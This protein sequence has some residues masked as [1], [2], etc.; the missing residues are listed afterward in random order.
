MP[1]ADLIE[2]PKEESELDAG[3]QVSFTL[4]KEA[5]RNLRILSEGSKKTPR[6]VVAGLVAHVLTADASIK[7]KI[8]EYAD[9]GI[10]GQSVPPPKTG[11]KKTA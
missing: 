1:L 4:K 7:A 2:E 3:L 6:E 5:A 10:T 11:R 9:K 8:R